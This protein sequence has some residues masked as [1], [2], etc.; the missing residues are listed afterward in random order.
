MSAAMVTTKL[1]IVAMALLP[2]R[3]IRFAF[4]RALREVLTP[5]RQ[6]PR[7]Q[8]REHLRAGHLQP[9]R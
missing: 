8:A 2:E 1:A 7:G 5:A 3:R 9:Q 4:A 6:F